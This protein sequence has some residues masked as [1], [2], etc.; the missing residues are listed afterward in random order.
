MSRK[1]IYI[2]DLFIKLMPLYKKIV[3][4]ALINY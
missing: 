1:S 4:Y 3:K 2:Y